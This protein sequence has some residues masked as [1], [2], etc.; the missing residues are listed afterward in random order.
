MSYVKVVPTHFGTPSVAPVGPYERRV[1][2]SPIEIKTSYIN[3]LS[4]PITIVLRSGLKFVVAPE[5]SMI[6]N[7]LIIRT[8]ITINNAIKTEVQKILSAI[9]DASAVGLKVL[10]DAYSVQ[11]RTNQHN[12]VV[13]IIDYSLNIH[14]LNAVGGTAYYHDLDCVV[15]LCGINATPAH[16]CSEDGIKLQLLTSSKNVISGFNYSIELIDNNN[17]FGPRYLNICNNIYKV[18]TT[19]DSARKD[20]A[21]ITTANPVESEI[22]DNAQSV[23]FYQFEEAEELLGLFKTIE[24]A[25]DLGDIATSRKSEMTKLEHNSSILKG[26][27]QNAKHELE[28]EIIAR[29]K[30]SNIIEIERTKHASEIEKLQKQADHDMKML[31]EQNKDHYENKSY[32]RKDESEIIKW[33]PTVIIGLGAIFM[34]IKAMS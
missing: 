19:K 20:G 11:T 24:E 2:A 10:R 16:P 14:E 32:Q 15:S 28:M 5:F 18:T 4:A 8:E 13:L 26:E 27:L 30:E 34:T 33:V 17:K 3:N 12:G 6:C 29:T 31:R 25:K 21:Y 23:K 7:K 22:T 1:G 9:T